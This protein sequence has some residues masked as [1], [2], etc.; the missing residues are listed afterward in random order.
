MKTLTLILTLLSAAA[1][2]CAVH[3]QQSTYWTNTGT[4]NWD[5]DGN[6]SNGVPYYNTWVD[7]KDAYIDNGGTAIVEYGNFQNL[8]V[9]QTSALVV[10][11]DGQL[12][13][14]SL[15]NDAGTL[16][17]L[18]GGKVEVDYL[19]NNSVTTVGEN[20]VVVIDRGLGNSGYLGGTGTIQGTTN[21]YEIDLM[22][23]SHLAST[24]TIT[25]DYWVF[26]SGSIIDYENTAL[27]ATDGIAIRIGGNI[28]I[29]FSSLTELGEVQ[30]L[31]WSGA[32]I[33][34]GDIS[35]DQFTS[36]GEGVE[37]TFSVTNN[38]LYFNATAVPEPSTWFLLGA[39]LG[40]LALTTRRRRS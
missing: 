16:T 8:H 18:N 21:V 9:D 38:Q 7:C 30:V 27:L 22:S 6:W 11:N 23:D 39:G 14:S 32:L 40:A 4:G 36:A 5:E 24:L 2:N 25:L 29:D 35:A 13:G 17:I 20:G 3:A 33:I 15:F 34:S 26:E 12:T 1:L 19:I 37:G 28:V 10:A 31:D